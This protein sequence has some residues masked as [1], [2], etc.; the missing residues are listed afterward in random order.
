MVMSFHPHT[1]KG[2]GYGLGVGD[3]NLGTMDWGLG[4]RIEE[5]VQIFKRN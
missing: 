5:S 4:G 2:P 3:Y 1:L